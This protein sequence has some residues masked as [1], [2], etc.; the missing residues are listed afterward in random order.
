MMELIKRLDRR[1]NNVVFALIGNGFILLILGI[2]IVWTDF[3]LRLTVGIMV[4]MVAY[5]FF[6]VSHKLWSIKD[7]IKKHFKL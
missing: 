4:L 3:V 1:I 6:Y 2:L 7:D 5:M